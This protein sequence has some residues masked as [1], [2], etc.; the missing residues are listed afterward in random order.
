MKKKILVAVV[1]LA[2]ALTSFVCCSKKSPLDEQEV[3]TEVFFKD[4][5]ETGWSWL[6]NQEEGAINAAIQS[7]IELQGLEKTG[8][9][10]D[11][12]HEVYKAPNGIEYFFNG[13]VLTPVAQFDKQHCF[14]EKTGNQIFFVESQEDLD[15][16]LDNQTFFEQ[17]MSAKLSEEIKDK[18]KEL[19]KDGTKF[20]F[21]DGVLYKRNEDMF[22]TQDNN[23]LAVDMYYLNG[24]TEL[25][26]T[27]SADRSEA[28]L[29]TPNLDGTLNTITIPTSL[30]GFDLFKDNNGNVIPSIYL[31]ENHAYVDFTALEHLLDWEIIHNDE[32]GV[33]ILVQDSN[34]DHPLYI[35]TI[36]GE[37]IKDGVFKDLIAANT[38]IKP[39]VTPPPKPQAPATP[40]PVVDKKPPQ[41][42]PAN[43]GNTWVSNGI[44]HRVN[45]QTGVKEFYE[46]ITGQWWEDDGPG[47]TTG[48]FDEPLSGKHTTGITFG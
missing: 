33:T 25:D 18:V 12:W 29:T 14:E 3:Y 27:L 10:K 23:K 15:S 37:V 2:I 7:Q 1:A 11:I 5:K 28:I 31:L 45:P 24:K 9:N 13:T 6:K 38:K 4:D 36:S 34:Y 19:T 40:P 41:Q 43:Q 30:D 26:F 48:T 32:L 44:P 39:A 35:N 22:F 21:I 42:Q 20:M 17:S 47:G 8:F 46:P 16:K